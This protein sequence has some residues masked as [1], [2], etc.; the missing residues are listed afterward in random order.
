VRPC[1]NR[2]F[3]YES[4]NLHELSL[5]FFVVICENSWIKIV[6]GSY[7]DFENISEFVL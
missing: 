1:K 7:L 4:T 6:F 5:N 2:I 3:K